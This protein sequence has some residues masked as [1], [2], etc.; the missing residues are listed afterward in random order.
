MFGLGQEAGEWIMSR[1]D[2]NARMC[3]HVC[4]CVFRKMGR[5]I[6]SFALI[7]ESCSQSLFVRKV[8]Q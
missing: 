6:S 4:A 7:I 2:R 3:V 5:F 1:K 8:Y